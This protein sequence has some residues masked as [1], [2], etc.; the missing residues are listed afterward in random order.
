M[1]ESSILFVCYLAHEATRGC[2]LSKGWMDNQTNILTNCS[3]SLACDWNTRPYIPTCEYL[4]SF[5]LHQ[6]CTHGWFTTYVYLLPRKR[7]ENRLSD[8]INLFPFR[9]VELHLA[10][11]RTRL[12]VGGRNKTI[13][14]SSERWVV[15]QYTLP[16]WHQSKVLLAILTC[17]FV[18]SN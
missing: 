10:P 13:F 1:L 15:L 5:Q 18:I 14:L 16:T 17:K 11:W 7:E 6:K 8:S 12:T 4:L 2:T 9:Q 3:N